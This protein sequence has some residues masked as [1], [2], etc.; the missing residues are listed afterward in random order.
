MSDR[1]CFHK[2]ARLIYRF[3]RALYVSII[4][5]L[6]PFCVFYIQYQFATGLH[7]EEL[8]YVDNGE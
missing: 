3:L 8:P 7:E 5:Y 4:F 2:C 6:V 1:T